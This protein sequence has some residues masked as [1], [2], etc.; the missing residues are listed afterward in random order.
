MTKIQAVAQVKLICEQELW[1]LEQ[2]ATKIKSNCLLKK[3]SSIA[4]CDMVVGASWVW[5]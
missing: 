2:D 3:R 5:K 1:L 4:A